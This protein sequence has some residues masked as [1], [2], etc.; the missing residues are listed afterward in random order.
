MTV[1]LQIQRHCKFDYFVV[2]PFQLL[3]CT[4]GLVEVFRWNRNCRLH[5]SC[6]GIERPIDLSVDLECFLQCSIE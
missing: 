6:W 3:P 4:A 1:R 2:I 5:R